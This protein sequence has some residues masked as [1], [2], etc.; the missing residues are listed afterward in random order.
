MKVGGSGEAN[1][2]DCMALVNWDVNGETICE[3]VLDVEESI[4]NKDMMDEK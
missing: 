3:E 2:E 4:Q 1:D